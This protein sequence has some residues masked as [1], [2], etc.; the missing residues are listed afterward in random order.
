MQVEVRQVDM[1]DVFPNLNA[2]GPAPRGE[3][4]Y[5]GR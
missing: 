3:T 2:M 1:R 5:K 4:M